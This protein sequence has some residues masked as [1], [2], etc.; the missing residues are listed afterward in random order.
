MSGP[1]TTRLTRRESL[2]ADV[3]DLTF[4]LVEPGRLA[5]RAGQFVSIAVGRDGAGKEVRRSYS[6]ASP[7]D[8]G[9]ALRF[10][11][12][13]IPGGTASDY[14]RALPLEQEVRMTGPHGYFV[15][16]PEHLGDVVFGATGTGIAAVLPML[17]ELAAREEP[18]RRSVYWGLR[19]ERDLFAEDEVRTLCA[20]ARAELRVFLSRPTGGW[21]GL[22]G[23]IT[24]PI[25]EALP[26]LDR[27][28]FYLVG[29]GAMIGELKRELV[30][31]GV[32]RK[33]QIR[34]EAFFD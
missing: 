9:E 13:I 6:I 17:V 22:R 11:V 20:A 18:G 27:P 7:S 30:S 24:A 1:L 33:R 28:T 32:E 16:D 2:A 15:L 3:V 29:N 34:T 5:F 21:T 19:E 31:R 23:R 14:F 8:R 4:S 26:G 10:L 25:V 12:K